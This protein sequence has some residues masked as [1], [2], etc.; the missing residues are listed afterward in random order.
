MARDKNRLRQSRAQGPDVGA[1]F[2]SVKYPF[3][4]FPLSLGSLSVPIYSSRKSSRIWTLGVRLDGLEKS[5]HKVIGSGVHFGRTGTRA[6]PTSEFFA[7]HS[8]RMAMPKPLTASLRATIGSLE[9][10]RK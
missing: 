2:R 7:I 8:G 9:I 6:L 3:A 5:A 4:G 10:T 1:N